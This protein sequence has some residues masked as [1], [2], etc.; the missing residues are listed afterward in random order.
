MKGYILFEDGT[1][2]EG[3]VFG[4]PS[5]AVGEVVFN[6]GMTGYQEIVTDPS[7]FGQIVVLTYPLI[8][9]YG[10]NSFDQQSSKP[11]VRALVVREA[12]ESF[13]NFRS[14]ESLDSYLKRNNIVGLQGLDTRALVAKIR[15]K[16]TL[17]AKIVV[18]S[19]PIDYHLDEVKQFSIYRHAQYV[20]AEAPYK[21]AGTKGK[22]AVLDFGIKA[23]IVK[24]LQETGYEL[25]VFPYG[26]PLSTIEDYNPD[27]IF[28]SNGPGDPAE[29]IDAIYQIKQLIGKK[30]IFGICLGHQM[31]SLAL[32]GK[33]QKMKFGHRGS[34]HPVK[35]LL[36][37]KVVITAQNHSYE[38][39]ADSLNHQ[40][41]TITHQHVNDKTVEG[42]RSEALNILSVQFHPEAS[43][44]PHD[45][46]YLFDEFVAM[47]VGGGIC[48]AVA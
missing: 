13:S 8:G 1:Q 41:L 12:S 9:N 31:L 36:H 23:G 24:M 39:I 11:H 47:M 40:P 45:S 37:D 16:G 27:G 18:D 33:T 22:I 35:D 3:E 48:E 19:E 25:M 17:R 43:P 7:Y 30:P 32:G 10:I 44:G 26:T 6:T 4:A 34:N 15:E 14:E 42:Y 28:L 29:Y 2:F 21:I 20:T 38:V 5:N 46:H